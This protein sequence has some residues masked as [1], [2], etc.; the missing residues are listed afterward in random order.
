MTDQTT[1]ALQD[2]D[3]AHDTL[4]VPGAANPWELPPLPPEDR[5][6]FV[7]QLSDDTRLWAD[8]RGQILGVFDTRELALQALANYAAKT[9]EAYAMRPG[10]T[11]KSIPPEHAGH[12]L[13]FE[14]GTVR[15]PRSVHLSGGNRPHAL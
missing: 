5:L 6:T 13:A 3:P 14:R 12:V 8:V 11:G 7:V 9:S 15:V 2:F 4:G 10:A 1:T